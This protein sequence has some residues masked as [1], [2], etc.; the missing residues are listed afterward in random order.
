[1]FINCDA[2]GLDGMSSGF[3][4]KIKVLQERAQPTELLLEEIL[5]NTPSET[6]NVKHKCTT[7]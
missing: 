5:D 6:N 2:Y 1:M 7:Y 4:W 3:I